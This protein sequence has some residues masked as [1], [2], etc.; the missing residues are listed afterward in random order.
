MSLSAAPPAPPSCPTVPDP[1]HV[2]LAIVSRG[3]MTDAIHC[4]SVAVVDARGR[5]LYAAGNPD[6]VVPTRSSLKPF[7]AMPLVAAGGIE[8][9]RLSPA[10]LALICASHSGEARHIAAVA[11]VLACAGNS[12]A[13][14]QC[15]TQVPMH[16]E[17]AG[18][19][20]PPPPYS[21]L[22]HNCSGKHAGML[23]WCVHC[24]ASKA[25][26]LAFG[27]PLQ[28]AIRAAVAHFTGL[29][30]A[31]LP[32]GVDGCSAPNYAVPLAAL[33]L[34]FARLACT[35]PDPRY[36]DAPVRIADAMTAHPEM[37]S[38]E[39]RNDLAYMRAGR[40]DW[41]TKVG[42]EGIQ[43]I[44]IRSQGLGIAVKV[45]D[46]AKRGLHPAVVSVLDQLGLL[47]ARQRDELAQWR[48]PPVCNFRGVVTG[49]V[50]PVVA[51]RAAGSVAKP[52][53]SGADATGAGARP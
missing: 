45:G 9:F 40:G 13:D 24:G 46:G 8:R 29:A 47:D 42:A 6:I 14:L 51:L 41:V 26:Y 22:A 50:H 34:A 53:D 10:Q 28:V 4:G 16:Y 30:E 18:S 21:P 17:L 33:A 39:R 20:P 23:A 5:L 31:A 52:L 11:D 7:Q 3:T 15:G 49:A 27:H 32:W 25:D 38:G 35:V 2:P 12:A 43:G 48:E 44:G 1:G 36:G 19:F 37:V